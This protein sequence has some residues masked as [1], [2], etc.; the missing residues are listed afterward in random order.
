MA[1][2]LIVWSLD[3][4]T[5]DW[6]QK[7][8]MDTLH[9]DCE[10]QSQPTN[11][12][13]GRLKMCR[14]SFGCRWKALR[15]SF[16]VPVRLCF[17]LKMTVFTWH[18]HDDQL[19]NYIKGVLPAAVNKIKGSKQEPKCVELSCKMQ[20]KR[21]ISSCYCRANCYIFYSFYSYSYE[22]CKRT[23]VRLID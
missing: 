6:S 13:R 20:W 17:A 15:M 12:R 10:K 21:G 16:T 22:L 5:I 14:S 19:K 4:R 2:S 3:N 18:R 7:N 23:Y 8:D 9:T 1:R 11:P